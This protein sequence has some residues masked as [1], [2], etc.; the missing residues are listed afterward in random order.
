MVGSSGSQGHAFRTAVNSAINPATDDLGTLG[1]SFSNAAAINSSGQVAGSS[2][3]ASGELHAFRL[4]ANSPINP[5][6]DD[7]GTLG[8]GFSRAFGINSAGQVVGD[9]L[10][11]SGQF[12]A[13]LYSGGVMYDL[14][15]LIPSNSGWTLMGI[16]GINDLGQIAGGGVL[17]GALHAFRL[18]PATPASL[19]S[20]LLNTMSSFNLPR[21][22]STDLSS[23]LLACLNAL[24]RGNDFAARNQIGA[25]ENMVH[26]LSG[27][28]LTTAQADLLLNIAAGAI[29]LL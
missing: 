20:L 25:F 23:V 16:A 21:G 18:D 26:A 7:L 2:T 14:N 6:T 27:N 11:A 12:H 13:F 8:G 22:T 5:A 29:Q 15:N 17:N 9:S 3:T 1:G 24:E 28:T 4:A 10:T 19:T